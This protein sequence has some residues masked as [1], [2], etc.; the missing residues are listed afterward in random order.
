[1]EC[2]FACKCHGKNP[3]PCGV[4][5]GNNCSYDYNGM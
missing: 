4:C 5:V 2:K 1:M 3:M